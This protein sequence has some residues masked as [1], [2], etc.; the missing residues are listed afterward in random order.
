[1][2][3][4][5]RCCAAKTVP[6][7]ED[8]VSKYATILAYMPGANYEGLAAKL[9]AAGLEAQ[10][11]CL[12]VSHATKQVYPM[13]LTDLAKAAYLPAPV[14][15]VIGAV[16][17]QYSRQALGADMPVGLPAPAMTNHLAMADALIE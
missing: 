2:F 11:P 16:A 9:R 1:V 7:W 6:G 4:S 3:L 12:L 5:N 10:T 13:T 17:G 14:L 15:L 8:A